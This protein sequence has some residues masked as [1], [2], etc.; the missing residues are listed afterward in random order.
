MKLFSNTLRQWL[1]LTHSPIASKYRVQ[2]LPINKNNLGW[3]QKS[4]LKVSCSQTTNCAVALMVHKKSCL[5]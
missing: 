2:S 1:L 5:Y 3:V 4:L